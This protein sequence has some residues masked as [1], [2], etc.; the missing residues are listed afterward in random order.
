MSEERLIKRLRVTDHLVIELWPSKVVEPPMV[1]II[2]CGKYGNHV[3]VRLDEVRHL[4]SALVNAA[5]EL[6]T[7]EMENQGLG[8][9]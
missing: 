6:L 8:D 5:E 1:R 9:A 3:Y 2:E 7:M 4:V